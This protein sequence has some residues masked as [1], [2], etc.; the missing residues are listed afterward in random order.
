LSLLPRQTYSFLSA[1][2]LMSY[3]I[4][5]RRYMFRFAF[6]NLG[7]LFELSAACF[8]VATKQRNGLLRMRGKAWRHQGD[9]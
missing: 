9:R 1:I 5:A 2:K 4:S 6:G 7:N 8:T 3:G